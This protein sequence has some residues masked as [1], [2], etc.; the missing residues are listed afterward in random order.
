MNNGENRQSKTLSFPFL[1][2]AT[3]YLIDFII[4]YSPFQEEQDDPL[5]MVGGGIDAKGEGCKGTMFSAAVQQCHLWLWPG[6]WRFYV[7]STEKRFFDFS[8]N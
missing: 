8:R 7:D 4:L 5:V 1:I 3:T 6:F 2:T